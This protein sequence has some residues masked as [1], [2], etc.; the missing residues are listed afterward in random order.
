MTPDGW[1]LATEPLTGEDLRLYGWFKREPGAFFEGLAATDHA[2]SAVGEILMR[3]WS[4][5]FDELV[6][7][8]RAIGGE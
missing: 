5:T 2:T 8:A 1:T 3:D 6:E 7:T 4:G